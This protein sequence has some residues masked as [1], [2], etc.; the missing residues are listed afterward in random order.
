ME[1]VRPGEVARGQVE[2]LGWGDLG[3][4]EW[5]ARGPVQAPEENVPVQNAER[6]LCMNQEHPATL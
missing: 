4:E 5:G 2:G 3:W 1:K 6:R